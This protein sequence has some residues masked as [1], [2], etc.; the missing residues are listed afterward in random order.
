MFSIDLQWPSFNVDLPTVDAW[1]K[2]NAPTGYNGMS[3]DSDLT[4]W[5]TSDPSEYQAAINAYWEG[6]STASPEATNYTANQT[7]AEVSAKVAAALAFGQNLMNQFAT[8]NLI[9]GIDADDMVDT[10]LD[11][12]APVQTALQGGSLTSVIKRI[13][14]VPTSSYD[15]KYVTAA[16]LL[17][18]C[19]QV[20]SYLG[21]PLST[22]LS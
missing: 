9:M 13:K 10:V 6:L 3:A 21:L 1:V 15:S 14:A 12:M 17:S 18:Y 4:I 19:N 11:V 22:S 8:E 20:E 7:K 5:Y 2:A 16:R